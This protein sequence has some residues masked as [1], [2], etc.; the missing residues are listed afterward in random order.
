[1]PLSLIPAAGAVPP[2]TGKT[3][4]KIDPELDANNRIFKVIL[5]SD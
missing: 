2:T 4:Q 3:A 5:Y 1:V